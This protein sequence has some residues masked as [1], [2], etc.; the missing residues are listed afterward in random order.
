M[1]NSKQRVDVS[2]EMFD[3]KLD[4]PN[5]INWMG[6]EQAYMDYKAGRIDMNE[7]GRLTDYYETINTDWFDVLCENSFSNKHTLSMSGGSKNM[8]YYASLGYND[9]HGVI[10]KELNRN[11][12]A[13]LKLSGNFKRFSFNFGLTANN[14][15]RRYTPKVEG[16]DN[17]VQ[18]A[19]QM[20]RAVPAYNEDGGRYF[21]L[22]GNGNHI[23]D[24]F[25]FNMENEM[26]KTYYEMN[27]HSTMFTAQLK[28]D[29]IDNLKVEGTMSYT[30]GGLTQETTYEEDS[31]YIAKLKRGGVGD[32]T[33][34]CPLG[35]NTSPSPTRHARGWRV[36][37]SIMPRCSKGYMP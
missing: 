22:K 1:M 8:K 23:E 2:R 17:I 37:N 30:M 35:A 29:I 36:C 3:R 10:K 26:E 5:V 12:T 34:L 32:P 7:F 20:N 28:Y 19:F 6:Y 9:E 18:Y 11:Y 14:N 31:Y 15:K 4:M 16:E 27:T 24:Y 33:S 13:S 21:Y 25:P